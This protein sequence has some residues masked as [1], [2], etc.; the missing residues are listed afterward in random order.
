LRS[1]Q[2]EK[3]NRSHDHEK[4]HIQKKTVVDFTLK[5]A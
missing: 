5:D 2:G 3:Y 4:A 1:S